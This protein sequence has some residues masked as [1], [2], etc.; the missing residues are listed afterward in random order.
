MTL[1]RLHIIDVVTLVAYVVA[2]ATVGVFFSRRQRNLDD[3]FR[4]RQSQ[5]AW[6]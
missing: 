2:L 1:G 6:D 5:Q 3:F 4:A